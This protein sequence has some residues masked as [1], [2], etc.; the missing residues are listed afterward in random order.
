LTVVKESVPCLRE[1]WRLLDE[2]ADLWD[3]SAEYLRCCR[4]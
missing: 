2:L 4:G 1:S 3:I